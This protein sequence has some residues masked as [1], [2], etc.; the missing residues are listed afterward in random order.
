[1]L[2]QTSQ[3]IEEQVDALNDQAWSLRY[4]DTASAIELSG[5][6][7]QLAQ[8]VGYKRGLAYSLR[9][10]GMCSQI[11]AQY[12]DALIKSIEALG[13]FEEEGDVQ[14]QASVLNT[15]GISY[16]NL[17]AFANALDYYLESLRINEEAN[18]DKGK[19]TAYNNIGNI[20][21]KQGEFESAL[22]YHLKSLELKEKISDGFGQ[23]HSLSNIGNVYERLGD[24]ANSLD[25]YIRSMTL[26]EEVGDNIGWANAI[27]NIGT[28]YHLIGNYEQS[29][30]YLNKSLA[31]FEKFDDKQ[32]IS[33]ALNN[34]GAVYHSIGHYS[35]ASQFILNALTIA[36]RINA[37]ELICNAYKSLAAVCELEGNFVD[38]VEYHKKYEVCREELY[39]QEASRKIRSLQMKFEV[40][41][42][43]RE[44][45]IYQLRNVELKKANEAL[46]QA[47]KEAER[48]RKAAEEQR[49]QA[50]QQQH[51]AEQAN[52][53]KTEFLGIAAHDL[54]NPLSVIAGFAGVIEENLD[55]LKG[56]QNAPSQLGELGEMVSAIKR[57]S[58]RMS[59]LISDLLDVAAME[60]GRVELSIQPIDLSIIAASVTN[61]QRQ[62]A[63]REKQRIKLDLAQNCFARC[64][65]DRMFDVLDNLVSN[66]IKYSPSGKT[67]WIKTTQVPEK[68]IAI[69]EVRDEGLGFTEE[70]K[71]K[72][73]GKFQRL[74][75]R[76]TAGESSTGLGLSIVKQV[77]ELHSG[78]VYAHSDGR[79]KGSL[80]VIE[81]QLA[82][83]QEH[84][85]HI[86]KL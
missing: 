57:N 49:K 42:A 81:L 30:D 66:A 46:S 2:Y 58:Q 35:K 36:Q 70:D 47:L 16:E 63:E 40:E 19:A 45:K 53:V 43:E 9:N 21:Q 39:N 14:G 60:Q 79:D 73:F 31:L 65:Y 86:G 4:T 13:L 76:P 5:T 37:L 64:D 34:I 68:S 82:S 38:A 44:K 27:L 67:I 50:E 54:R 3:S 84:Q 41:R 28:F 18:D 61:N 25:Y 22:Q 52:A 71:A 1:M 17:G 20:Y 33:L 29:L 59:K 77:V 85:T 11:L 62:N 51:L 56:R 23:V 75:A 6:A 15:I 8:Q 26:A 24:V 10:E 48:L 80:F 55:N 69:F 74:S 32:S 12:E 83:E 72:M 7:Y 78:R